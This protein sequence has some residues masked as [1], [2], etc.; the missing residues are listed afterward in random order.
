MNWE[1]KIFTK[2]LTSSDF[3]PCLSDILS[4]D[5]RLKHSHK[6]P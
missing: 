6:I 3:L 2:M 4:V 5:P 1:E